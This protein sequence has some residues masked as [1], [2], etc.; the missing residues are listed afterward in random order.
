VLL[1]GACLLGVAV[2]VLRGE[3]E[4]VAGVRALRRGGARED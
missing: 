4:M 2:A 1:G 3:R